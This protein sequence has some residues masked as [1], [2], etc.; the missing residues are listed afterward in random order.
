[1][2]VFTQTHSTKLER[3][4]DCLSSVQPSS[5]RRRSTTSILH[6]ISE[7]PRDIQT[8]QVVRDDLQDMRI[9]SRLL[10]QQVLRKERECKALRETL[11][12]LE[13]EE[14]AHR[15]AESIKLLEEESLRRDIV[16]RLKREREMLNCLMSA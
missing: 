5:I 3:E 1:M 8:L 13:L 4:D 15:R 11:R 9:R 16:L 7:A 14:E 10:Q 12:K 6:T 2:T